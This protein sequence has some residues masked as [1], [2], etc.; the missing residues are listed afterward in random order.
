LPV[1]G[2]SSA[3]VP[4]LVAPALTVL[5]LA[6]LQDWGFWGAVPT[7]RARFWA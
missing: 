7:L 4:A 3:V 5:H 6:H 1:S 2:V